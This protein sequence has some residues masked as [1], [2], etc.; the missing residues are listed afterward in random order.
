[1]A[2]AMWRGRPIASEAHAPRLDA[3]L[4]HGV[5]MNIPEGVAEERLYGE[6]RRDLH[7]RAAAHH[8][9][10]AQLLDHR[11]QQKEADRHRVMYKMHLAEAG[12][13]PRH[14]VP[15]GVRM[16]L[17]GQ[18]ARELSHFEPHEADPLLGAYRG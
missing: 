17:V 13:N 11:G 9:K 4:A 12:H 8:A 18:P 6:Y 2:K 10:A 3:S 16:H 14:G 15:P 7:E 5:T 1:M